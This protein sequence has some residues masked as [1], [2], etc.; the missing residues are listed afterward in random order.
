MYER[1]NY[2]D[3]IKQG[4]EQ[5]QLEQEVKRRIADGLRNMMFHGQTVEKT[6]A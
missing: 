4:M 5:L 6:R 1:F 2:E 3:A